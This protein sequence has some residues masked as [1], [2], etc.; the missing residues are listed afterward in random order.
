MIRAFILLLGIGIAA[1]QAQDPKAFKG[2]PGTHGKCVL[3]LQDGKW[4][5]TCADSYFTGF[6]LETAAKDSAA[7]FDSLPFPGTVTIRERV[8]YAAV[9]DLTERAGY[10]QALFKTSAGWF[11]MDGFTIRRDSLLFIIDHDPDV[12][13]TQTDLDIIARARELLGDGSNWHQHDDRDCEQDVHSGSYSLYCALRQAS[14]EVE[15]EYNHRN[16][17][18]QAARHII[19]ETNPDLHHRLRDFN[20]IPETDFGTVKKLLNRLETELREELG[21]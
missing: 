1:V 7:F 13:A 14:V 19:E 10:P 17:V 21:E 2:V 5:G 3:V 8:T 11:T 9:F 20:N 6:D 12:P 4:Q 15:G 18:M 16:A